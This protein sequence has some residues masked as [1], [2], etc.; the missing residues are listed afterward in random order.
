MDSIDIYLQHDIR[1]DVFTKT[2][3]PEVFFQKRSWKI[4]TLYIANGGT[5]EE[6]YGGIRTV[7]TFIRKV[8]FKEKDRLK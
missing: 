2:M 6:Y 5:R 8:Y 3:K 4:D 7:F 1:F